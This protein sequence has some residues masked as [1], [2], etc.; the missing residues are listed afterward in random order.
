METTYYNVNAFFVK[1]MEKLRYDDDT[2][3]YIVGV[4]SKFN[5]SNFD[6]SKHSITLLY[7]EAKF[8]QDFLIFQNIGD[9]VFFCNTVF[10]EHLNNASEDYYHSIAQS[11]YYSCYR[12][13]NR[14]WKVYE[15]MADLFPTLT[16]DTRR[17]IRG[18]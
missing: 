8:K 13:I 16:L 9:W 12:L 11:S 4:L 1:K 2:K 17:V 18:I 15:Q 10:P 7:A 6:Y 14:Q 3:S 5:S